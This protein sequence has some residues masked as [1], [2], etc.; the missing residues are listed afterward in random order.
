MKNLMKFAAMFFAA[1]TL[2][3]CFPSEGP[4]E[5]PQNKDVT[6][7]V[8]IASVG[9]DVATVTV[10]HNGAETDTWYGFVTTDTKRADLSLVYEKVAEISATDLTT[11]TTKNIEIT[12]L[13]RGTSYK[14]VVFGMGADGAI[15]GTA[16]SATFA[17]DSGRTMSVNNDWKIEYLGDQE[18]QGEMYANCIN[19]TVPENDA[20]FYYY[21]VVL[22]EDWNTISED[23]YSYAEQLVPAMKAFVSSLNSQYGTDYVWQD[24]LSSGSAMYSLGDL[25]PD[26]YVCF[27]I[28]INA[29][30]S[31]TRTYAVSAA[32]EVAEQDATP[33]YTAWFGNWKVEG[34]GYGFTETGLAEQ[35]VMFEIV[36]SKYINNKSF[37]IEGW[38][39]MALPIVADYYAEYDALVLIG[40]LAAEG[41]EFSDGSVADIYFVGVGND[42]KMYGEGEFAS[43]IADANGTVHITA[44]QDPESGFAI[45]QLAFVG[46]FEDGIYYVS[47]FVPGGNLTMTR[48][49]APAAAP[50]KEACSFNFEGRLQ[51]P[52]TFVKGEAC[53]L[54]FIK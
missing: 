6:F 41:V 10:S 22:A 42:G 45:T 51:I 26:Q 4:E 40:Q 5:Q 23:I 16:G 25:D 31:L 49:E 20:T 21:D 1:V 38:A 28:G 27:M 50:A 11:G 43:V 33:E 47:D 46:I 19:I 12:G 52:A 14:Y 30:E 18:Y 8:A 34:K 15:Y 54:P 35:D 7:E 48:L 3:S 24:M 44:L 29:D 39:G 2:A 17:T 37:A 36:L 9:E 13:T 53:N 32:F